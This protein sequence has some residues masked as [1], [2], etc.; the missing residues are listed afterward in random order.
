MVN[1]FQ[2]CGA[3][4]GLVTDPNALRGADAIVLPGVGAFAAA[5]GKLRASGFADALTVEVLEKGVPF[6]GLCLGLQLL[7]TVG[8]EHGE[9]A[10]LNW[11]PGAARRLT[12]PDETPDLRVPHMG[13]NDVRFTKRDGLYAGLGESACFYFVHSYVFYPD[14][15]DSV[16]GVTSHGSD[17]AASIETGNIW[18][19]QYHPEKSHA[20]GLT[21][22]R[23]FVDLSR[24]AG[25]PA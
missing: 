14:D 18:A 9:Q 12:V 22:L 13:W 17:F 5:M 6:L 4:A 15:P 3:E 21:V 24:R 10:G 2:A 19:T 7:A 23:N 8:F 16:S 25:R 1:A 20:A 11:V